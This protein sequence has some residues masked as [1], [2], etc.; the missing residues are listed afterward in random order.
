[1][2]PK[3]AFWT[4]A[5]IDLGVVLT[6]ATL[7]VRAMRRRRVQTHRRLMV[8]AASLVGVFLVSYVF[9]VIF[10]GRESLDRWSVADRAV[11]YTH[12]LCVAA[13]L[14][15]GGY[16]LWRALRFRSSLPSGP[17]LPPDEN[18]AAGRAAH[19][20]AGRIAVVGSALAF[21]TATLVL[22]GMYARS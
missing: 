5:W 19:R 20:R 7:G 22:I 2:D 6:C 11:L 4:F 18:P 1:M 9:K 15:G 12:E 16:A 17:L 14:I 10:L 13:M 3:L 8:V 21:A